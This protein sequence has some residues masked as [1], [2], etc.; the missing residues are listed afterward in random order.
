MGVAY[1][2]SLWHCHIP[3][4]VEQVSTRKTALRDSFRTSLKHEQS[5]LHFGGKTTPWASP[6]K[7]E[8]PFSLSK[9]F[10]Q[11]NIQWKP[12]TKYN[13]NQA[14]L[15]SP[16]FT[17]VVKMRMWHFKVSAILDYIS[18]GAL[19][20]QRRSCSLTKRK[21]NQPNSLL[22]LLT[23]LLLMCEGNR[24]QRKMAAAVKVLKGHK[25]GEQVDS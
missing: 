18:C 3:V 14:S 5:S 12:Y 25:E 2:M 21:S 11:R 16:I 10:R 24:Q 15:S 9:L 22:K 8:T 7:H 23:I 19:K 1:P 13:D 17:H 4:I 6:F 20:S